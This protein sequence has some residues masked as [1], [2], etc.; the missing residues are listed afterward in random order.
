MAFMSAWLFALTY[1][2]VVSSFFKWDDD[3]TYIS[4]KDFKWPTPAA[5]LKQPAAML[6]QP[7]AMLKQWTLN[8]TS[9]RQEMPFKTSDLSREVAPLTIARDLRANLVVVAWIVML[10]IVCQERKMQSVRP[11]IQNFKVQ[12]DCAV[13]VEL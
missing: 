6:K 7:A 13:S 10:Y 5:Q 11:G 8:Q 9:A 1:C 4:Q 3:I 12:H 2:A